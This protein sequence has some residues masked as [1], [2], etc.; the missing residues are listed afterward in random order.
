VSLDADPGGGTHDPSASPTGDARRRDPK[1][2]IIVIAAVAF[3]LLGC[4]CLTVAVIAL[5]RAGGG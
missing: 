2:S 4:M 1:W 5:L 3:G